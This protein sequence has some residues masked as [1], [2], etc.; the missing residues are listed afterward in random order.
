MRFVGLAKRFIL[1]GVLIVVLALV[2]D[3][4]IRGVWFLLEHYVSH[5]NYFLGRYAQLAI[6]AGIILIGVGIYFLGR[7]TSEYY[8]SLTDATKPDLKPEEKKDI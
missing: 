8:K 3:W 1:L 2:W 4:L 7:G 5:P 6:L